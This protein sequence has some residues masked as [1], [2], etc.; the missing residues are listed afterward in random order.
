MF[1]QVKPFTSQLLQLKNPSELQSNL[2]QLTRI[3]QRAGAEGLNSKGC[4]D[5]ILFPL[6]FGVDSIAVMRKPGRSPTIAGITDRHVSVL[7]AHA[8]Q[9][10]RCFSQGVCHA[11]CRL[12]PASKISFKGPL[13]DCMITPAAHEHASASMLILSPTAGI[14][15]Q[16]RSLQRQRVPFQQ[17]AVMQWQ[18]RCW[19]AAMHCCSGVLRK[20][21]NN[22]LSCWTG[23]LG[24]L[25]CQVVQPQKRYSND[26]A[27]NHL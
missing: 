8:W 14:L 16:V 1:Q 25:V 15:V 5:Y 6:M 3:I 13:L 2:Q 24:W 27:S 18:K 9:T 12:R 11:V 26:F 7:A 23:L 21:V 22:C 17:F 4:M 19:T 20:A 10:Q